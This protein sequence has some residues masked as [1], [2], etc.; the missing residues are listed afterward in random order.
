MFAHTHTH[1]TRYFLDYRISIPDILVFRVHVVALPLHRDIHLLLSLANSVAATPRCL[2]SPL[3]GQMFGMFDHLLQVLQLLAPL[4]G[5]MCDTFDHLLQ[6]LQ[7]LAPLV[8]QMFGTSV[9]LHQVLQLLA[10]LV[11]VG[12]LFCFGSDTC[13]PADCSREEAA[14]TRQKCHWQPKE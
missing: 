12:Q 8:G 11:V 2:A 4:V 3:V 14:S 10:P 9:H 7:L 1:T 13:L 5:Q 6:V